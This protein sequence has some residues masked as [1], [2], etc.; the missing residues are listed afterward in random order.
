[1]IGSPCGAAA[2]DLSLLRKIA[3]IEFEDRMET[4]A[5]PLISPAL[6][7]APS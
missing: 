4:G 6:H 7:F 1:M 3:V 2:M 5:R